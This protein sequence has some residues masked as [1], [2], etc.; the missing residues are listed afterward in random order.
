SV[1]GSLI[2]TDRAVHC[3]Q[4]SLRRLRFPF[5]RGRT[6]VTWT[7]A[8]SSRHGARPTPRPR[9][10]PT[11]GARELRDALNKASGHRALAG[12]MKAL[13]GLLAR[14]KG[15]LAGDLA[16]RWAADKPDDVLAWV[17]LG[18]ALRASG[19]E[20]AAARAWGSVLDLYPSRADL[21]RFAGNLLE[22]VPAGRSLA[23]DTYREAIRQRPDHPSGYV[24]LALAMARTG[25]VLGALSELRTGLAKHRRFGRNRSGVD[26]TIRRMMRVLAGAWIAAHPKDTDRVTQAAGWVVPETRSVGLLLLTWETDAND[27]DLHVFSRSKSHAYF[28]R[29]VGAGGRL[30][31]DVTN[32]YGP[33]LFESRDASKRRVLVHYYR[34]GPMGYGVGRVLRLH[35]NGKGGLRFDDRTFVAMKDHAWVDLGRL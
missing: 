13:R 6:M 23:L 9:H 16:R 10:R 25:N 5:S 18:R 7:I 24:Q 1:R 31:A 35:H 3:V 32:G 33:E 34:R 12:R 20:V 28:S 29:K 21:R 2:R 15:K 14:K 27:V 8:L 4:R 17:A 19:H 11:R 30:T 26:R 22:Q